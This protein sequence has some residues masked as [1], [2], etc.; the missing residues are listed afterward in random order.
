MGSKYPQSVRFCLPLW[1][2][3]LQA[4][5]TL[6]FTFFISY[7]TPSVDQKFME[8]YQVLQDLTLMAALGFGFLSSTFRRH[9]WSSVAFSLFMLALGVQGTILLDHVL[10]QPFHWNVAIN[11]SSVRVATLS[12]MPVLI[13]AGA[14]LGKVNLVQLAVMVLVEVTAFG[15]TRLVDK[16]IFHV[17]IHNAVLAGG[18]A[19][20]ASCH[21]ISSPWIAMVLGLMAGLISIGGAKCLPVCLKQTLTSQVP[22][23]VHYTFGFPGLLGA[24]TYI[25]LTATQNIYPMLM[26]SSQIFSD[27]GALSFA[28]AM[29]MISG[30]V[31]GLLLNVKIWK[32][33]HAAKYFDDQTFWE[34]HPRQPLNSPVTEAFCTFA[35]LESHSPTLL[36]P[37]LLHS[38][39]ENQPCCLYSVARL[40]LC[41]LLCT[42]MGFWRPQPVSPSPLQVFVPLYQQ[43]GESV[44]E[45]ESSLTWLL[46]FKQK[47]LGMKWSVE[48][49]LHGLLS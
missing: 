23:G 11:L 8:T 39:S 17:H 4:T 41:Q 20:G 48:R 3:A 15:T 1:A 40:I 22:S 18:V 6:L 35:W 31:T 24:A 33:P 36:G 47:H 32:A 43:L 27:T 19:V 37:P 38:Y 10:R 29:G 28:M 2:L 13:S 12:T 25:L 7:D 49:N 42:A 44:K 46:D 9:G 5:F 34:A 45:L 26:V 16:L 30:L 21:L 14:V